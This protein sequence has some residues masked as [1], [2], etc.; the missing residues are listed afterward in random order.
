MTKL[1][2]NIFGAA[3][4]IK[5]EELERL[6]YAARPDAYISLSLNEKYISNGEFWDILDDIKG[7]EDKARSP[8]RRSVYERGLSLTRGDAAAAA[9]WL[10]MRADNR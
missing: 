3:L 2:K 9:L 8:L 1:S 5:R 4:P 7:S 10:K 6:L